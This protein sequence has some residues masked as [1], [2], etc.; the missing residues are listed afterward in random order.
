MST[1]LVE[2]EN[3]VYEVDEVCLKEKAEEEKTVELKDDLI[4][5]QQE[6]DPEL[7]AESCGQTK[8]KSNKKTNKNSCLWL[9]VLF[10]CCS[11]R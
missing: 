10:L 2:D 3:T 11:R 1:K 5:F 9:I 4:C 8:K 7:K 6:K